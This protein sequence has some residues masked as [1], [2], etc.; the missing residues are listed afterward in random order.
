M[1]SLRHSSAMLSSP[2]RPAITMRT[3]S[4]AEY[5]RRVARLISRTA[6]SASSDCVSA[7]DLISAPFAL[8]MSHKP[9]LPQ[10][11]DSVQLVLTGNRRSPVDAEPEF[12][13]RSE[14]RPSISVRLARHPGSGFRYRQGLKRPHSIALRAPTR[15]DPVDLLSTSLASERIALVWTLLGVGARRLDSTFS[16]LPFVK[17]I[18]WFRCLAFVTHQELTA[19]YLMY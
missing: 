7:F 16:L 11:L 10:S 4:S 12:Q 13:F 15:A 6:F 1:P 19:T 18:C 9:S 17:I 5:N 8:K 2:R 3:F 14:S